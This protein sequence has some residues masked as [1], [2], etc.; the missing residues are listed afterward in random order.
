MG[1]GFLGLTVFTLAV[2]NTETICGFLRDST[3][4]QTHSEYLQLTNFEGQFITSKSGK[5]GLKAWLRVVL[6][7]AET[8]RHQAL[9]RPGNSSSIQWAGLE[10]SP[11]SLLCH[12]LSPATLCVSKNDFAMMCFLRYHSSKQVWPHG[13]EYF[14]WS[15]LEFWLLYRG[16]ICKA[17]QGFP[18]VCTGISCTRAPGWGVWVLKSHPA[19]LSSQDPCSGC[20]PEVGEPFLTCIWVKGG[21]EILFSVPTLP[22]IPKSGTH[23][24][25][26]NIVDAFWRKRICPWQRWIHF[27]DT[28]CVQWGRKKKREK[29]EE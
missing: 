2:L 12:T 5:V 11:P 22:D 15:S 16:S 10:S 27:E 23:L 6:S 18:Q 20:I 13:M 9:P 14:L 24:L 3:W 7:G 29:V 1:V 21:P 28:F 4:L 19:P 26:S 17:T 25:T 8:N